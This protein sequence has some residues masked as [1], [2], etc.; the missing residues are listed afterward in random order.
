[1]KGCWARVDGVYH[2]VQCLVRASE[3]LLLPTAENKAAALLWC[4][5]AMLHIAD[6]DQNEQ[7]R[8]LAE[9]VCR[10]VS[11]DR[12]AKTQKRPTPPSLETP[13]AR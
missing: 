7:A 9:K 3:A 2:A 10:D 13:A 11:R 12:A 5:R 4:S 8:A 1:M 6:S